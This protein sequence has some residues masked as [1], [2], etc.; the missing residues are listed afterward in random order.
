MPSVLRNWSPWFGRPILTST[1]LTN[2]LC[3]S[4]RL[5]IGIHMVMCSHCRNKAAH[6]HTDNCK[7][8]WIKNPEKNQKIAR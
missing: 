5:A 8:D 3:L 4:E 1:G 6:R 7:T 2:Q